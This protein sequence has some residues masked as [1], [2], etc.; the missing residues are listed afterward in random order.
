MTRTYSRAD[1]NAAQDAWAD[2]SSEWRDVRHQ[3]GMRGI[4]FPPSGTRWDSWDDDAPSQR[5][6]LIRA[7]RETPALLAKC[8]GR[9]RSWSE[10]IA[11]LVAG[12][13]DIRY[14][15]HRREH[16]ERERNIEAMQPIGGKIGRA[17]V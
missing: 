1:W 10:V 8:V 6:I 14:E 4:L 11:Q 9:S 2:F 3:A 17:H 16:D 15:S 13:D 7:I 12:R 5:A